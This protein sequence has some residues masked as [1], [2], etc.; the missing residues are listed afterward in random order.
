MTRKT[1]APDIG[2]MT[3]SWHM[4]AACR[5]IGEPEI[6]FPH[7]TEQEKFGASAAMPY[8]AACP[9]M[10]E[11]LKAALDG[12]EYGTWGGMTHSERLKL[13]QRIKRED[14]ATVEALRETLEVT[15]PRCV[16][17]GQHRKPKAEDRCAECFRAYEKAEAEAAEK[18]KKAECSE[19]ECTTE[20][21]AKGKCTRHYHADLRAAKPGAGAA[22]SRKSR[23]KKAEQLAEVA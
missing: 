16:D 12:N 10:Y 7:A 13:K 4:E 11:C 6:F 5:T 17:C 20:V 9:V 8:C 14:Y 18:A 2:S 23:A 21:H 19:D 3:P 15:L 1:Y 22:R